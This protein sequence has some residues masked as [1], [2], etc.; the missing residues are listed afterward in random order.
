LLY[1]LFVRGLIYF[2][3]IYYPPPFRRSNRSI[4][5]DFYLYDMPGVGTYTEETFLKSLDVLQ[6]VRNYEIISPFVRGDLHILIKDKYGI[7]SIIAKTLLNGSKGTI[8]TA[9]DKS[10]YRINI[11]KELHNNLYEYPN[12]IYK[13]SGQE[14]TLTCKLHGNQTLIESNHMKGFGCGACVKKGAPALTEELFQKRMY[15]VNSGI[16]IL[17]NYKGFHQQILCKNKYGFV[18]V[19]PQN[20]LKGYLGSLKVAT[21]KTSYMI[22]QFKERHNSLY[23]YPNYIYCGNRCIGKIECSIHGEFEQLSDVHLMGSGC[24]KCG[25]EGRVNGFGRTDFINMANGRECIYY[26]I[27]CDNEEESFYKM[28]ITARTVKDRYKDRYT[29]PYPFR[30][31]FEHFSF[32][33]GYIWDLESSLKNQYKS[34][35]YE[36]NIYFK[37]ITECF[38][39]SLPVDEIIENLKLS[40]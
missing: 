6:P 27:K 21:D 30:T 11:F 16:E 35:K 25:Q 8:R 33:A 24:K 3:N 28:G 29:M 36:P 9:I 23:S 14:I 32:D 13:D 15:E 17:E 7:C 4:R 12:Y 20:L 2:N 1:K 5:W 38:N 10:A 31:I 22:E 37:G 40:L 34:V 26:I 39:L 18:K 19:A